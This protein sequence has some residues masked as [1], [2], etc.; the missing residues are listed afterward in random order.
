LSTELG[1]YRLALPIARTLH[2]GLSLLSNTAS[3][4]SFHKLCGCI[5]HSRFGFRLQIYEFFMN[6]ENF[7]GYFFVFLYMLLIFCASFVTVQVC[8]KIN[9]RDTFEREWRC[10]LSAECERFSYLNSIFLFEQY[11]LLNSIFFEQ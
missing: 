4:I 8:F 6:K 7:L 11:F 1:E 5:F 3:F 9:H 10:C 2:L